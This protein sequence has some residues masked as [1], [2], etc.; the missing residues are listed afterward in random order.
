MRYDLFVCSVT[1]SAPAIRMSDATANIA[2]GSAENH[3][4]SNDGQWAMNGMKD[5]GARTILSSSF[6]KYWSFKLWSAHGR[7]GV[8]AA[9]LAWC[10]DDAYPHA[11]VSARR[12]HASVARIVVR[13]AGRAYLYRTLP[14]DGSSRQHFCGNV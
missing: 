4:N 2:K 9:G 7:T 13:R 6:E 1:Q 10:A 8:S 11:A 5:I 14:R 12:G 3:C